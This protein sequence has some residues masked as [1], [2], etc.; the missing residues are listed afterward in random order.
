MLTTW[1]NIALFKS[2]FSRQSLV[3]L[4]SGYNF[5]KTTCDVNPRKQYFFIGKK[6][7]VSNSNPCNDKDLLGFV[8][9]TKSL[10]ITFFTIKK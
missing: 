7:S 10:K 4:A 8:K 5:D 3:P 9:K 6:K 1:L 2:E